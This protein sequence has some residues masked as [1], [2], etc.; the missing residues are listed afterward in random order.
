MHSERKTRPVIRT[1]CVRFAPTGRAWAAASTEGL[2]IYSLDEAL[3][4]DPFDLDM[5]IT[6]LTI[7]RAIDVD[8]NY[9]RALVMA[10]RLSERDIV[11]QVCVRARVRESSERDLMDEKSE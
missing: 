1:K 5:D 9:A 6:P 7:R 8:R 2:L 10:L 4:F 3:T 11:R